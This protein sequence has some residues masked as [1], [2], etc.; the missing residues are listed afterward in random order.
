MDSM[1][2]FRLGGDR[3]FALLGAIVLAGLFSSCGGGQQQPSADVIVARTARATQA[4]KRFHFVFDEKN[5]PRSTSGVHLVFADGDM[6]VPDKLKAD[7]SGTF[8]GVPLRSSLVAVNRK[9]YLSNP[10]TGSWSEV[11]VKTNP[12]TFFD[13]AKGVLAV[14]RNATHLELAGSERVGGADAYHLEGK[15]TVGAVTPL[16][17]NP[18]GTRLVDV[19][20]WVDKETGRLVR[21]RLAGEVEQGDSAATERTIEIS[22]FGVVVPIVPP[23]IGA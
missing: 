8:Q 7:V 15:T 3:P 1:H 4:E 9:Y 5:G 12:V 10:F 18:P 21:L 17:G 11:S 16:L 2:L 14:V 20:L 6:V 23:K 22:R 19:E 13:P